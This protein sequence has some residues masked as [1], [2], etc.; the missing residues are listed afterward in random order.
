MFVCMVYDDCY[1]LNTGY[2][3]R[4][5]GNSSPVCV[6]INCIPGEVGK[7]NDVKVCK[8]FHC[9][10]EAAFVYSHAKCSYVKKKATHGKRC[11]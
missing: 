6:N 11:C 8:Y 7:D 9:I 2:H 5:I 10:D 3:N 1:E 4:Y